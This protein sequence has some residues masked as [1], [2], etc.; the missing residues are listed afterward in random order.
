MP[1]ELEYWAR[2]LSRNYK[3]KQF[4]N[5]YT[6]KTENPEQSIAKPKKKF[7]IFLDE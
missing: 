5:S 3:Q 4:E 7:S 6:L 1:V 2:N